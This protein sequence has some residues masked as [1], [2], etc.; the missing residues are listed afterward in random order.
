MTRRRLL[1]WCRTATQVQSSCAR[2]ARSMLSAPCMASV[3]RAARSGRP[4]HTSRHISVSSIL[5]LVR[6]LLTCPYRL[7][8]ASLDKLRDQLVLHT[9]SDYLKNPL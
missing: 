1:T 8:V 2:C 5:Q 6:G 9:P 7:S 3:S 4:S